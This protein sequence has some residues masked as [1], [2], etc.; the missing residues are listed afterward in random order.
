MGSP[1]PCR[2]DASARCSARRRQRMGPGSSIGHLL[3]WSRTGLSGSGPLVLLLV[4]AVAQ[5]G[6]TSAR[7]GPAM[8][9]SDAYQRSIDEPAGFW[10]EAAAEIEWIKPPSMV[11]DAARAPFYRWFPDGVMNTCFNALD[12]HVRDGRAD[13][14]ALIYDSP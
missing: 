6:W 10:R 4:S 9:Y 5:T 1:L 12:R 8:T 7:E 2:R 14:A 3:T 11:L 13:Q